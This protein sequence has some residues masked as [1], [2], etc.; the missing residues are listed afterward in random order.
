[1]PAKDSAFAVR[2]T[3]NSGSFVGIS[4]ISLLSPLFSLYYLYAFVTYRFFH[5]SPPPPPRKKS[6]VLHQSHQWATHWRSNDYGALVRCRRKILRLQCAQLQL[7]VCAGISLFS[8]LPPLLSQLSFYLCY[9]ASI[10]SLLLR[11][12]Y[13]SSDMSSPRCQGRF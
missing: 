7:Q 1:M 3:P 8:S 2:L 6:L 4:L 10:I 11:P 13:N 5:C 9:C 12:T